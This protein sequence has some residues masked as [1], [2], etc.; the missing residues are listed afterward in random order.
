[1][2]DAEAL[3]ML[4]YVS[5]LELKVVDLQASLSSQ[6]ALLGQLQSQ[7]LTCTC[8]HTTQNKQR[9]KM[10]DN[11]YQILKNSPEVLQR[12]KEMIEKENIQVIPWYI[13]KKVIS[14]MPTS[15]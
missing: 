2:D 8:C 3:E 9:N 4:A 11:K 15:D 6:R 10:M 12:A 1:M 13:K 5:T 14:K 7:L